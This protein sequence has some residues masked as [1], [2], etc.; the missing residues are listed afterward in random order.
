VK[1]LLDEL[2]ASLDGL[3]EQGLAR[4]LVLG[5][6]RDFSSN[7][8]LGLASDPDLRRALLRRFAALAPEAPVSA[9]ASRLLRGQTELHARVEQRLAA[10]KGTEAALLFPSG[11]QA[12]LGLITALVGRDD[13]VI[14]DAY[15]HASLIDAIRLAGCQRVIVPHHD[16][17]AIEAAL[18]S[19]WRAGRTFIV[20]ESLFSMDGDIAPLDRLAALALRYGAELLV[21]DAHAT[22]IFGATGGGLCELFGVQRRVTAVVSTLGKAFGLA[23]G[24][25]AGSQ[26]LIEYLVNRCRP[27]VFSTAVSPLLLHGVEV[28]LDYLADDPGRRDRLLALALGLRAELR[29]RGVPSPGGEGP[30]VPVIVGESARAVAVAARVAAAGFDVRAVRPPT[31]PAGS[32]RLRLSVHADHQPREL[33]ALASAVAAALAAV[34]PETAARSEPV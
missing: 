25:V 27:F 3:S 34:P 28:V 31:V 10:L 1:P 24:F 21:D 9:P 11:Y 16:G 18:S 5:C 33:A 30:I 4:H 2:R 19:P 6:G 26:T 17:T 7:D 15:N 32:A 29:R 22:G 20:T 14:S 8:Y 12:N 23:G 13:R